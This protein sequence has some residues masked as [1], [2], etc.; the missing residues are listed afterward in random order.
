MSWAW[1]RSKG[2]L[3]QKSQVSL[4]KA[5]MVKSQKAETDFIDIWLYTHTEWGAKQADIYL[6][7]LNAGIKLPTEN[8]DLGAD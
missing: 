4:V 7:E 3:G 1:K 2:R 5:D 6:D 8:P